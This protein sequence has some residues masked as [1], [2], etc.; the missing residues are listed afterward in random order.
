MAETTASTCPPAPS[1]RPALVMASRSSG[2]PARYA[3]SDARSRI[4]RTF[5]A[6]SRL[7]EEA[8]RRF[9]RVAT[10][11]ERT[12]LRP[13]WIDDARRRIAFRTARRMRFNSDAMPRSATS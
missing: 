1:T 9:G 10:M 4:R 2:R 5:R 13:A 12:L 3:R 7:Y 11:I 8:V 6:S